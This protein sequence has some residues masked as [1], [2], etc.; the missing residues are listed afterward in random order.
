MR[1]GLPSL[2]CD[3][4]TREAPH[5]THV[6]SAHSRNNL[7]SR[8]SSRELVLG[9]GQLELE[10]DQRESGIVFDSV[11]CRVTLGDLQGAAALV[12]LWSTQY[13]ADAAVSGRG[14]T[15]SLHAVAVARA[16]R[17]NPSRTRAKTI[18]HG[19]LRESRDHRDL[20]DTS[21]VNFHN[22]LRSNVRL[23]YVLDHQLVIVDVQHP[24][25]VQH[26]GVVLYVA[27]ACHHYLCIDVF[28]VQW[29]DS[30]CLF[31]QARKTRD[32]SFVIDH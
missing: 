2:L 12:L 4:C 8:L 22:G 5:I 28:C 10:P 14:K 25:V 9:G 30:R 31:V 29:V 3:L 19:S 18:C 21:N 13:H 20:L 6:V 24:L 27:A 16:L 23:F 26:S 1:R 11:P 15:R 7:N 17:V 32:A